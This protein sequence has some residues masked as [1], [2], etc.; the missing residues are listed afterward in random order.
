MNQRVEY[1]MAQASN[2]G[3]INAYL[4]SLS[5]EDFKGL[6]SAVV[7]DSRFSGLGLVDA[8]TGVSPALLLTGGIVAKKYSR[9]R[10]LLLEKTSGVIS[11]NRAAEAIN[12]D[13]DAGAKK[14]DLFPV[15]DFKQSVDGGLTNGI[16]EA[17]LEIVPDVMSSGLIWLRPN[18][19]VSHRE[20]G[21]VVW[22]SAAEHT[23]GTFYYLGNPVYALSNIPVAKA[24]YLEMFPEN[25]LSGYDPDLNGAWDFVLGSTAY[26]HIVVEGSKARTR[27]E[28]VA[29]LEA[30]REGFPDIRI[31]TAR[32]FE[33]GVLGHRDEINQKRPYEEGAYV[34]LVESLPFD[35]REQQDF[36]NAVT[37]PQGDIEFDGNVRVGWSRQENMYAAR[38][39]VGLEPITLS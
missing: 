7:D 11:Y 18:S 10:D 32:L 17:A 2:P 1:S 5:D 25:D 13:R 14:L 23:G 19:P 27:D 9:M 21:L 38:P 26:G 30:F 3:K 31:S 37:V 15:G 39:V 22:K 28:Q 8:A 16:L 35:G 12:T 34:R 33:G 29:A 24:K 20:S 6:A 36:G 4:S